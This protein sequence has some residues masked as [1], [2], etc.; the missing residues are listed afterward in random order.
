MTVM[1]VV[2]GGE[3]AFG[4]APIKPS[5]IVSWNAYSKQ[6]IDPPVF[7][8]LVTPDTA[9]YRAIATQDDKTLKVESAGP[10]VS[11]AEIWPKLAVKTFTLTFEWVDAQG[12]VTFSESAP[13]VKAPDWAGFHE[14][15][16]DWVAAADRNIAYLIDTA[17]H[18]K[19]PYREPG[20]PVWIWSAASPTVSD[21]AAKRFTDR[22]EGL[23][24]GYPCITL[25][26][27]IWAFLTY[28]DQNRPQRTEA[29]RLARIC[30]DWGLK[31]RRPNSGALPLF[32]YSTISMGKFEGGNEGANV[33]MLRASW[34]AVSYVD[35]YKATGNQA[36]LDY[37]IHIAKITRKF[38]RDD[39]SF[40]CRMQP[41]T[42]AMN[43]SYTCA[44]IEFCLLVDALAPY[45]FDPDLAL[46]SQRA[47]DW[48]LAYVCHTNHWQA[49][50]EDVALQPAYSNLSHWETQAV[51]RYLCRHKNEDPSYL[52]MAQKLNRWI[53][54][55]FIVF[56]PENEAFIQPVRREILRFKG[57]LVFEQFH[58]WYPMEGHTALW[59]QTLI[60]LHQAT[61]DRTYLDKA[62]ASANAICDLQFDDGQFSTMGNRYYKDGK[63][64]SDKETGFNWYN[65][66]AYASLALYQLD[67]YVKSLVNPK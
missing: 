33:N 6:F 8:L 10:I 50:F 38:Q 58:C 26:N 12:K 43:E 42:G 32:P 51:I 27:Y 19:A 28:A 18:G 66:N 13:R 15:P 48:T 67:A 65:A 47:L 29:L 63:M 56:G 55:Q 49:I 45:H 25:N 62:K 59:I 31:N 11:L 44:P 52:P 20:V 64:V 2:A 4:G 22:P 46:A 9:I 16:A 61:G 23:P 14:P 37:A 40:P 34:L 17:D 1:A 35:I 41:D 57:P 39:G 53:E 5:R 36:Y 24:F 60:A 30:A 3:A 7:K 21:D 54:D